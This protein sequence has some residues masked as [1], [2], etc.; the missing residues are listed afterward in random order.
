MTFSKTQR[1]LEISR[2]AD[3]IVELKHELLISHMAPVNTFKELDL[4]TE[5]FSDAIP[6]FK[7]YNGFRGSVCTTVNNNLIHGIPGGRV[8]N[9]GDNFSIDIHAF[10]E[11]LSR[12]SNQTAFL[13]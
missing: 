13:L 4:I 1:C 6:F 7:S 3:L 9:E 11:H 10:I 12:N 2:E 8:L 5:E